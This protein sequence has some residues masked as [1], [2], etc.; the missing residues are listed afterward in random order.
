M[1]L[2]APPH[3]R[4]RPGSVRLRSACHLNG[5]GCSFPH[6]SECAAVS[7]ILPTS[8][9]CAGRS[10]RLHVVATA[11]GG[12][13]RA[14]RAR[15][16]AP[17][18]QPGAPS[19]QQPMQPLPAASAPP[20]PLPR[21]AG[22]PPPSALS[23]SDEEMWKLHQELLAQASPRCISLDLVPPS[24]RLAVAVA[25]PRGWAGCVAGRSRR[26]DTRG[27][28]QE[29]SVLGADFALYTGRAGLSCEHAA[30]SCHALQS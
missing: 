10:S 28:G 24:R 20:P 1:A 21:S 23:S 13:P 6:P 25:V 2:A 8:I 17:A 26:Q 3:H 29:T 11:A 27:T 15:R 5:W 22:Q 9:N 30:P 7:L 16:K 19:P 14:P 12:K 4:R 18:E